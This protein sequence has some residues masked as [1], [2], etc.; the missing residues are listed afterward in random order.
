[1]NKKT[2]GIILGVLIVAVAGVVYFGYQ[3]GLFGGG[4]FPS[5]GIIPG[6]ESAQPDVTTEGQE[7][8]ILSG[9]MTDE[10]YIEILAH[11][12]YYAQDPNTF[13]SR[14][15]DFYEKYGITEEDITAYGKELE[16]DP[17][18]AGEIG[19]KYIQRAQ[20]LQATGK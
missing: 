18:R 4:T 15:K 12:G 5:G 19:L 7:K 14:M 20:E 6:G 11:S 17:Q 2:L 9:K 1:M 8:P 13:A 10:I 16:K 3:K